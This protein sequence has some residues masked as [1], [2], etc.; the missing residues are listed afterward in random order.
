MRIIPINKC[1][2]NNIGFGTGYGG[3]HLRWMLLLSDEYNFNFKVPEDEYLQVKGESWP[4]YDDYI[5]N[6][7]NGISDSIRYE[8]QGRLSNDIE[9]DNIKNKLKFIE[10]SVYPITRTWHNWIEVEYKYRFAFDQLIEAKHTPHI[11]GTFDNP[12][13]KTLLLV[14]EPKTAYKAIVK[15]SIFKTTN[16][17]NKPNEFI[18]TSI[19]YN[20]ECL[21]L[22]KSNSHIKTMPCDSLFSSDILD[23]TW[24]EE[25]VTYFGL[26]NRY[27]DASYIHKIWYSLTKN[28]EREIV[29]FFNELYKQ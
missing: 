4:R 19:E 25:L 18:Q 13:N 17:F 9:F 8:M 23:R 5:Y 11:G 6:N 1:P 22:A 27:E 14:L 2:K 21:Q 26:T 15:Y 20:E 24:Y 7:Y 16:N 29:E 12:N 28:A 10:E 3:N